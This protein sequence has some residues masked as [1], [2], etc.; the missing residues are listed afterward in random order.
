MTDNA[1]VKCISR[2]PSAQDRHTK[3][4]NPASTGTAI[5]QFQVSGRAADGASALSAPAQDWN[6][7]AEGSG[8]GWGRADGR[9][10]PPDR[11]HVAPTPLESRPVAPVR[12]SE[13]HRR[14]VSLTSLQWLSRAGGFHRTRGSGIHKP[15]TRRAPACPLTQEHRTGAQPSRRTRP[16]MPPHREPGPPRAARFR[17][18]AAAMLRPVTSREHRRNSR[19]LPDLDRRHRASRRRDA[20]EIDGGKSDAPLPCRPR[21]RVSDTRRRDTRR[22]RKERV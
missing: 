7:G 8:G 1:A 19:T 4:L 2:W 11:H 18:G 14:H 17:P 16:R 5:D 20:T 21:P 10:A 12:R 9:A 13:L 3:P 6:W 22:G 15:N